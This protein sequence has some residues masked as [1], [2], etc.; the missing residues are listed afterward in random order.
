LTSA[1]TIEDKFYTVQAARQ[2]L[3]DL[4]T[5]MVAL[6][7]SD[8]HITAGSPACMRINGSLDAAPGREKLSAN[9]TDLLVRSMLSTALWDKF[10]ATHEL[11]TAYTIA[12]VS[13]FR[14]NVFQQRGAV[15]AVFRAIP[16]QIKTLSDLGVPETVEQF[17]RLQRG[18]V[19]VT[20]P[21]GSGKSTTLASLIELA[22]QSRSGHIVTIE[23]PI[24]YL[25]KHGRSLVN[26]RE[27]GT[28]TDTFASALR[29]V[30][31]QDPDVILVGE[32]RDLETTSVAVTAA[33]TGH[34]VFAT[35]HTQSAAQTVERL[36]DM[37]PPYAQQQIRS[38]VSTCLQGVVSQALLP[39]RDGQGR[40]LACEVMI[41]TA[42]IRNLIRE[43]KPHQIPSVLQSSGDLGMF[44]FD[45]H[46]AILYRD[47]HISMNNA[48]EVAHDPNEFRRL[49]R[50]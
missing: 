25:H 9:D 38:Q 26:Q 33:E 11:D 30:L 48:L 46:L 1:L 50:I 35:M 4:L 31:R 32:M 6:D 37:Y 13:R 23:D 16:Y 5:S 44:S 24:E 49:A 40:V 28:D 36:I 41:A 2:E 43:G 12:G 21:T 19:L 42:A 7:G 34:L 39:S 8:L 3:D 18:L 29:H 20:G 17:S 45:Q 15:G 27:V 47:D 10:E 14:V 22:N